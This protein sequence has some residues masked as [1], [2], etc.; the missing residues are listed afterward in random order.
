MYNNTVKKGKSIADIG[1]QLDEIVNAV[2]GRKYNG[3]TLLNA[4]N[5][6]ASPTQ[7]NQY[8]LWRYEA[9]TGY[10]SDA[11]VN[12]AYGGNISTKRHESAEKYYRLY[13]SG[14]S[15]TDSVFDT[16]YFNQSP[17]TQFMSN[18]QQGDLIY[19]DINENIPYQK[20][21]GPM[22]I[23]DLNVNGDQYYGDDEQTTIFNQV[24]YASE[25]E[26]FL[27]HIDEILVTDYDIQSTTIRS[28]VEQINDELPEYMDWYFSDE[29]GYSDEEF[30]EEDDMEILQMAAAFL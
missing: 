1:V 5:R 16:G 30:T 13:G 18:N 20:I 15:Y 29:D 14:D 21:N 6:A 10:N 19:T 23:P 22:I 12:K 26:Q 24:N 9:G 11:A 7:A 17:I 28:L 4:I 2:G 25:T 27:Q 3:G 8:F